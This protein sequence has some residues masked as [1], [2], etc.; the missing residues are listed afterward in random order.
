LL[1]SCKDSV[2]G[3]ED[4]KM[5]GVSGRRWDDFFSGFLENFPQFDGSGVGCYYFE[6]SSLR[7]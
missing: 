3:F 1:V 6:V 7:S 2:I 4:G 5:E